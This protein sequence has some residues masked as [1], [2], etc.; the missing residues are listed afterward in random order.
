MILRPSS[1]WCLPVLVASC[2]A[3]LVASDLDIANVL[4]E[5]SAAINR[6]PFAYP[7]I[8][9]TNNYPVLQVPP[10]WEALDVLRGRKALSAYEIQVLLAGAVPVVNY[11]AFD[12]FPSGTSFDCASVNQSGYYAD[13][14]TRCQ[15]FHRCDVYGRR[16]AYLCPNQTVFNQIT[17]VCDWFYNVQCDRSLEF[18]DYSNSRLYH[19]EYQ[20]VLLDF[21]NN[22]PL[23]FLKLR[24]IR[25]NK[26][27]IV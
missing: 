2:T 16:S 10:V 12:T 5:R 19:E 15:G 24:K 6:R 27:A 14:E 18:Y 25:S 22:R 13:V 21:P 7:P 11:P 8:A 23:H 17:L 4:E 9:S 20:W 3:A 1:I 26:S